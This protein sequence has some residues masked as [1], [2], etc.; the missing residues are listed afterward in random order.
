MASELDEIRAQFPEYAN[1]SDQKLARALKKKAQPNMPDDQYYG[2][3]GIDP[4]A[5][6]LNGQP[7]PEPE[8]KGFSGVGEDILSGIADL[9]HIPAAIGHMA[10][11]AIPQIEGIAENS[12]QRFG[13]NILAGLG[14]MGRSLLNIPGNVVDYGHKK[15]IIPDWVRAWKPSEEIQN[16]DYAKGVGLEDER[17]GDALARALPELIGYGA[18]GEAGTAGK[19]LRNVQRAG[20]Y[21]TQSVA[22]NNNPVTAA[23]AGPAL[24]GFAALLKGG[25]KLAKNLD[26]TPSGRIAKGAEGLLSP[27]EL[28]ANVRAAEGTNTGLGNVIGSPQLAKKLTGEILPASSIADEVLNT[29]RGQLE[30]RAAGIANKGGKNVGDANDLTKSL[31]DASFKQ[32]Q[33][34]KNT[35]YN[36]VTELAT[37]EGFNLEL[38]KFNEAVGSNIS[39]LLESPMLQADA[40]LTSAVKNLIGA[41]NKLPDIKGAK[42][43]ASRFESEASAL[44]Q[45]DAQSRALKGLYNRAA[46]ALRSDVREQ[47]AQKGSGALKDAFNDAEGYYA[48]EFAQFLEKDIY[49]LLDESKDPQALVHEIIKPSKTLDKHSLIDKVTEILPEGQ[50]DLLGNTYLSRAIGKDGVIQPGEVDK[51]IKALGARQFKSLFP[52]AAERQALLD[53]QRLKNMNTEAI[54]RWFDPKTGNRNNAMLAKL[55]GAAKGGTVGSVIGGAVGTYVGAPVLGSTIGGAAGAFGKTMNANRLAKMLTS[56]EFRNKVVAKIQNKASKGGSKALMPKEFSEIVK[57]MMAEQTASKEDKK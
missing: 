7:F 47:I 3:L 4:N 45:P 29:T 18:A 42:Y 32:S 54:N 13:Q 17:P 38:P 43:I 9:R 26:L 30:D 57:S 49:K 25:G 55:Y 53:F 52:D 37:K 46:N 2:Q 20:A 35:L 10:S 33:T 36:D 16:F 6:T 22:H 56:E 12:P 21:G 24:E 14:D 15:E 48:N 31:L 11:Q 51:L 41:G 5:L 8:T 27:E 50:K 44:K 39:Q 28:A 19:L 34:I 1:W 23:L 40:E